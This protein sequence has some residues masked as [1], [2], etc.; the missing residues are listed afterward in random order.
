[1]KGDLQSATKAEASVLNG[2]DGTHV[3]TTLNSRSN[4]SVAEAATEGDSW[5]NGEIVGG[6]RESIDRRRGNAGG[7]KGAGGN[8]AGREHGGGE[9]AGCRG[10]GCIGLD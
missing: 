8:D 3:H 7:L 6:N 5:D 1:M 10:G 4:V 9:A 2:R